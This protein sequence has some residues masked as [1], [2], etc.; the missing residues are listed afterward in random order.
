MLN[1]WHVQC[2][3]CD[4]DAVCDT[5]LTIGGALAFP[6][7]KLKPCLTLGWAKSKAASRKKAGW[8]TAAPAGCMLCVCFQRADYTVIAVVRAQCT[9]LEHPR[10]SPSELTSVLQHP[11][12]WS[13]ALTVASQPA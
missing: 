6:Q 11:F 5:S 13:D 3:A 1:A 9:L 7:C 10:S 4:H 2:T 12:Q 8:C